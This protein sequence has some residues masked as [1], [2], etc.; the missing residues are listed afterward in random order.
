MASCKFAVIDGEIKI[1][2]MAILRVKCNG[3]EGDGDF[4]TCPFWNR[5][6]SPYPKGRR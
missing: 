6:G 4:D 1:C 2:A 3:Y 5:G